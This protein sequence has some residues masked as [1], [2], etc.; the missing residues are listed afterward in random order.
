MW[1]AWHLIASTSHTPKFLPFVCKH[2]IFSQGHIGE[3]QWE[4]RERRGEE[5]FW[6]AGHCKK[7]LAH[8]KSSHP[9]TIPYSYGQSCEGALSHPTAASGWAVTSSGMYPGV[10]WPRKVWEHPWIANG[11]TQRP[12]G[13][14]WWWAPKKSSC[15]ALGLQQQTTA[16]FCLPQASHEHWKEQG[17]QRGREP[18]VP[19]LKLWSIKYRRNGDIEL[20]AIIQWSVQEQLLSFLIVI[21][22]LHGQNQG[23]NQRKDFILLHSWAHASAQISKLRSKLFSLQLSCLPTISMLLLSFLRTSQ[24][25]PSLFPFHSNILMHFSVKNFQFL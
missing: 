25:L 11:V 4:G 18:K 21:M 10:S 5:I 13:L 22:K 3:G 1:L 24:E 23:K 19:S 16:Q 7:S 17:K 6:C 15:G 14:R 12:Q 9:W 20:M 2:Y 8:H